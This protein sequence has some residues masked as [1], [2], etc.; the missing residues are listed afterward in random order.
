[1]RDDGIGFGKLAGVDLAVDRTQFKQFL[2][3]A[4]V[5][6]SAALEDQDQV[7]LAHRRQAVGDDERGPSA[8]QVDQGGTDQAFGRRVDG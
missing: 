3:R 7:G 5:D 6:E 4:G 8:H 1:M 2:V